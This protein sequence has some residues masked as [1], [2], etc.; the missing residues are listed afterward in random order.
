M[1]REIEFRAWLKNEKRMVKV[2]DLIL[3]GTGVIGFQESNEDPNTDGKLHSLLDCLKSNENSN[4]DIKFNRLLGGHHFIMFELMQYTGKKD[5]NGVKIFEHDL[6]QL[7][8]TPYVYEIVWD[9]ESSSYT[10]QNKN[11]TFEWDVLEL[12]TFK[13]PYITVL[14]NIYENKELLGE[15][16]ETKKTD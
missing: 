13:T 5:K 8:G 15:E 4:T 6:I 14:G 10:M 7:D 2:Q 9:N 11:D 1:S 16:Y 12:R 3:N